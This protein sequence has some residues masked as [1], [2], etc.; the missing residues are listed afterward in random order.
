MMKTAFEYAQEVDKQIDGL[1]D[2]YFH[3]KK[4]RKGKLLQEELYPLSRLALSFKQPGLQVLVEG[5]E[6]CR[7]ADGKIVVSGFKCL[8]A[9]IQITVA[10]YNH[11]ES[12]R[13]E[14][15]LSQG[16]TPYSGDIKR[17]KGNIVA[18]METVDADEH[19]NKLVESIVSRFEKKSKIK[20]LKGTIL[21]I[22][23]DECKLYSNSKWNLLFSNLTAKV[24][25]NETPFSAIY[26]FNCWTN[27][28]RLLT[29]APLYK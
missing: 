12:L 21:L 17:I 10:G 9:E 18:R 8:E 27:Q 23:F 7:P 11:E 1:S 19:F 20:Y 5:F 4:G 25:T 16:G 3:L 13:S 24:T 6:D 15:L 28:L 29:G 26:L 2:E 22:V 14:L